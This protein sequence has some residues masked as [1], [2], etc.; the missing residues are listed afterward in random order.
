MSTN[1]GNVGPPPPYV[2][3]LLPNG[4]WGLVPANAEVSPSSQIE[5]YPLLLW[6]MGLLI[7]VLILAVIFSI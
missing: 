1:P 7:A 3:R 2:P 5:A 6:V 4:K